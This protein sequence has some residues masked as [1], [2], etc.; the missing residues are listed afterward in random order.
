M[1][2]LAST[3]LAFCCLALSSCVEVG[4]TRYVIDLARGTGELWYLDLY[5]DD[6]DSALQDFQYLVSEILDKESLQESNPEWTIE[7]SELVPR[8]EQLDGVVRFT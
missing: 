6:P 7:S 3:T 8:E 4:Q 5:S 2:T 1:R